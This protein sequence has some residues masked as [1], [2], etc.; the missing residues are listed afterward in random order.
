MS[1]QRPPYKQ[2]NQL[3]QTPPPAGQNPADGVDPAAII[4]ARS[5]AVARNR[6]KSERAALLRDAMRIIGVIVL[7]AGVGWI[8][9]VKHQQT[10]EENREKALQEEK[11]RAAEEEK[12]KE[13]ERKFEE[14]RKARQEAIKAQE[15]EK[16]RAKEAERQEK[17]AKKKALQLQKDNIK[18]YQTAMGRFRGATLDLLSAAPASDIPAK[19]INESWFSCLVPGGRTGVALYEIHA[20]PGKDMEVVLLD[21]DGKA[22]E[23]NL[24]EF[25]HVVAKTSFLLSKG[26]RC[27]Y[28]PQRKGRW[29]MRIPVPAEGET[30]D[31]SRNDFRDLYDIVRRLGIGAS[32]LNYEV[33]FQELGAPETRIRVVPFGGTLN[34]S[35][36]QSGLQSVFGNQ[37]ERAGDS[38]LRA[39]MNGGRVIIRR[40]GGAR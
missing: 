13:R 7:V 34:R 18:R 31:P 16:Q 40:K 12:R 33:Y 19:V 28:S 6:Q 1:F 36:I 35:D 5:A 38:S 11:K 4:A 25:N 15:L 29:E 2:P 23:I 10:K 8:A 3:A 26:A 20:S 37:N 39:R 14:Q 30:L 17:E 21:S 22:Q 24:E 9:H 27:Y 32:S